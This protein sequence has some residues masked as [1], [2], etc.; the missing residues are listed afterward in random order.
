MRTRQQEGTVE[1]AEFLARIRDRGE[2]GSRTRPAGRF[3]GHQ[4]V[5]AAEGRRRTQPAGRGAGVRTA[6]C[7]HPTT[8]VGRVAARQMDQP[9]E[10]DMPK[11]IILYG[12][13]DD[14]AAFEDYYTNKH[15]PY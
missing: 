7:P 3:G 8:F 9:R 10:P 14:P 2:G 6:Q 4:P 1:P 13:P 12:Q 5:R 15:L 11:L